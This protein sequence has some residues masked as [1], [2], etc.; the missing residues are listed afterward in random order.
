MTTVVIVDAAEEQLGEI[1]EWWAAHR[2]ASPLLVT[3][4]G[5]NRCPKIRAGQGPAGMSQ[6]SST[7]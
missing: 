1:V 3:S 7:G 5:G 6:D 4:S 2:E